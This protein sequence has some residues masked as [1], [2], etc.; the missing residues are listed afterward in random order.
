MF[1]SIHFF[2]ELHHLCSA[3]EHLGIDFCLSDWCFL[4]YRW[5][6]NLSTAHSSLWIELDFFFWQENKI[7]QYNTCLSNVFN[8]I[9]CL[10]MIITRLKL[11]IVVIGRWPY[12]LRYCLWWRIAHECCGFFDAIFEVTPIGL[13]SHDREHVII[14]KWAVKWTNPW[15]S[16]LCH[17][18]VF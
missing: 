8:N 6:V 17:S 11:D 2:Y 9:A 16:Q 7:S 5:C 15:L 4:C 1:K 18:S 10:I 13:R 14:H 12:S 3:P